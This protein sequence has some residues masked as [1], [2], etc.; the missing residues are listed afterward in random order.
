MTITLCWNV[1]LDSELINDVAAELGVD[2]SF[3]E[4]DYYAVKVIRAIAG[5]SHDVITPIFC[6][7]TSLSKGYDILKRFSEDIDFRAQFRNGI[8]PGKGM[9]RAFRHEICDLVE[10][11]EGITLDRERTRKG[12]SHF[13]VPLTY[14]H[15]ADI[16]LVLRPHLQLDFTY[17][18][19]RCVPEERSISSF[20][21]QFS[22][23]GSETRILCLHPVETAA[24]KFCALLWRVNRRNR[25]DAKDDPAPIRH[26][27]DLHD[28]KDHVDSMRK[29][30]N[31]LVNAS[32]AGDQDT[33]GRRVDMTLR[34]TIEKMLDRLNRD[35]L[36]EMEYDQFVS[37]MSYAKSK[38]TASFHDAIDF[39]SSLA[40]KFRWTN[41]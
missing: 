24:D 39:L 8:K 14:R 31:E 41:S 21:E 26:L 37:R 29:E 7:G 9:L 32:F 30:F 1:L 17:T 12:G 25:N 11:I 23:D 28:L 35:E 19:A 36:Y 20:M 40:E 18:Q 38:D 3:V 16:S 2:A 15:N 27:H 4:K 34:E 5:Y 6:G 22:S 13:K 10:S 33:A